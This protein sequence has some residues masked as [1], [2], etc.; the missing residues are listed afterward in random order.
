MPKSATFFLGDHL[1]GF[2]I[3]LSSVAPSLVVAPQFLPALGLASRSFAAVSPCSACHMLGPSERCGAWVWGGLLQHP[4]RILGAISWST[5]GHHH[6]VTVWLSHLLAPLCGCFTS[7]TALSESQLLL[8][9][10]R[11]K[12]TRLQSTAGIQ[13]SRRKDWGS[14]EGRAW[15]G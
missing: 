9:P 7:L 10:R 12:P 14:F 8:Q 15:A 6:K 2:F 11:L 5:D 1:F 4:L 13:G 3:Q